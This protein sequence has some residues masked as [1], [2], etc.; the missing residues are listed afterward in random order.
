MASK[1]L[2][3]LVAEAIIDNPPVETMTD[4]EIIIDWSPT[5]NAVL[6]TILAALQEPSEGMNVEGCQADDP[7]GEMIDWR[8]ENCTPREGVAKVWR[9]MLNA[10]PLGE[11]SE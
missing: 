9:A 10:S 5:T 6:S 3:D 1:E 4:A 8:G 11:Q 7:L 2:F